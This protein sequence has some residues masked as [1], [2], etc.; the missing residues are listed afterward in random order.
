P[1]FA[2]ASATGTVAADEFA[3]QP[4]LRAGAEAQVAGDDKYRFAFDELPSEP[5]AE[6]G[7][8]AAAA[9]AAQPPVAGHDN[10]HDDVTREHAVPDLVDEYAAPVVDP[11]ANA[12]WSASAQENGDAMAFSDDPVDTKLDLARAYL[13]MGDPSG[14]RAMLEEVSK[15]GTQMQKDEA[16]R[17]L[18]GMG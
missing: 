2:A 9:V 8:A 10:L 15:E 1:L 11:D 13:D 6:P 7:M 18:D 5:V 4:T 16:K 3:D 12:D 17:L 14:A